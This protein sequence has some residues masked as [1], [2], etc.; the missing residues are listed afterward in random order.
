MKFDVA[1]SYAS[2]QSEIAEKI[3]RTL[4]QAGYA[5]F[6]APDEQHNMIGN[7][8]G[9]TLAEIY[10][11]ES[12]YCLV[13]ASEAYARKLPTQWELR[14]AVSRHMRQPDDGYILPF[15]VDNTQLKGLPSDT[16]YVDLHE[17][18]IED[19]CRLVA[20]RINPSSKP[21]AEL[22]GFTTT[23]RPPLAPPTRRPLGALRVQ[24]LQ[25]L[26][27]VLQK[28]L[29]TGPLFNLD[30]V[31]ANHGDDPATIQR[32]GG[33]IM[34]PNET[35]YRLDWKLFYSIGEVMYKTG[36]AAP[37][38]LQDGEEREMGIQFVGPEAMPDYL[39]PT[40]EYQLLLQGW[41]REPTA[42]SEPAIQGVY[43]FEITP[44]EANGLTYWRQA[45]EHDWVL[46]N[47]PHDAVGIPLEVLG[48]RANRMVA[49]HG[50]AAARLR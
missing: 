50:S 5:V 25:R 49:R 48:G 7:P 39:W 8:L 23:H 41:L 19:A 40:G 34:D 46:L 9:V 1:L 20:K 27:I 36:D 16:V 26:I 30:C 2:E 43:H 11:H 4:L 47:D 33:R 14:A 24:P 44:Y 35:S 3:A 42:E 37:V 13:I 28:D 21:A 6:Y 18:T 10:E 32:I 15:R 29:R 17:T 12:R 45:S 31:V 38:T 22:E